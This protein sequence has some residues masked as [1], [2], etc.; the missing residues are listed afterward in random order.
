MYMNQGSHYLYGNGG[1]GHG[2]G[3]LYQYLNH[4]TNGYI[5]YQPDQHQQRRY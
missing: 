1:G 5:M 4:H 3:A 2:H